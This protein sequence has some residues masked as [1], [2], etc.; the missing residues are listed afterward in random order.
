MSNPVGLTLNTSTLYSHA[1]EIP[2][3]PDIPTILEANDKNI[4]QEDDDD[5]FI[6]L[7][8]IINLETENI[9]IFESKEDLTLLSNNVDSWFKEGK[10]SYILIT[11]GSILGTIGVGISIFALTKGLRMST[12]LSTIHAIPA[13]EAFKHEVSSSVRIDWYDLF[14]FSLFNVSILVS[15]YVVYRL[16]VEI[17]KA[18]NRLYFILPIKPDN[19][20]KG[21]QTDIFVEIFDT[22]DFVSLKVCSLEHHASN[23]M[24]SIYETPKIRHFEPALLNDTLLFNYNGALIKCK[25]SGSLFK[26]PE[27]VS[28]PIYCKFKFRNMFKHSSNGKMLKIRLIA[29]SQGLV[30]DLLKEV[31]KVTYA[32]H[33]EIQTDTVIDTQQEE[34]CYLEIN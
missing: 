25:A 16:S 3:K 31:C 22:I 5:S 23:L 1:K 20:Y 26:I 27:F 9:P 7:L 21:Y 17:I 32:A 6:D 34:D 2:F 8:K 24:Q 29:V 18:V 14:I 11:F 33:A 4:A 12:L 28:I 13:A 19:S 30:Y 10:V 15:V